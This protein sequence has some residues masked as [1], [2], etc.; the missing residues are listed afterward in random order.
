MA[1]FLLLLL[2]WAAQ[3]TRVF[4]VESAYGEA[5]GC[6]GCLAQA[7]LG[8]DAGF[9]IVWLALAWAGFVLK[10]PLAAR[11][12]RFV[13]VALLIYYV[14]DIYV[15]TQFSSRM[16]LA[17]LMVVGSTPGP[18]LDHLAATVEWW[19]WGLTLGALALLFGLAWKQPDRPPGSLVNAAVALSAIAGLVALLSS[20]PVYYVHGWAV[21]SVFDASGARTFNRAY[22]P[23]TLSK[24]SEPVAAEAECRS[25]GAAANRR[26]VV[27]LI[28]ESW[29]PYQS[30]R[31]TGLND[32]TPRLDG[33]LHEHASFDRM[34]A[35]GYSTNHGLMALLTGLP[36]M[37]TLV[38]PLAR[39]SLQPAW[40]WDQTLPRQLNRAGYD[41]AFLTSGD[42]AFTGKGDW[43]AHIGFDYLEGHD[44]PFY[45][46]M[47]RLHFRAAPDAALYDRVR[48]FLS[49]RAPDASPLALVVESVSSHNPF[50]HPESRTRD[51][52]AVFRYMDE[53]AADFIEALQADGF[54]EQGGVLVVVSDHRAMK[55]ISPGELEV[56]DDE[57]HARIPMMVL[58][59]DLP[60]MDA[61]GLWVQSDVG[62]SLVALATGSACS[63]PGWRNLFEPPGAPRCVFHSRGDDR[64]L[65]EV[66]CDAG[67]GT[68]R[69]AGDDSRFLSQR[70][71]TPER[72]G[73]ILLRL[74][75]LR[76]MADAHNDAFF[77]RR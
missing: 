30:E 6:D 62:A 77:D 44:H 58:G 22:G 17:W 28:L 3:A 63:Y 8:S 20:Q 12:L 19:R 67:R 38:P 11:A 69:L 70:G 10:Q 2:A 24:F 5:A 52:E 50:I 13:C 49:E 60:P 45:D 37:A 21:G 42:L 55:A 61:S 66:Y 27:V 72:Q 16:Y 1:L 40:G 25:F 34:M 57:A 71:L 68:V 14:L 47:K 7:A 33:L 48:A 9:W 29:S 18:V 59:E 74:A 15:M 51:E 46:G 56:L 26:D 76:L 39:R 73:E 4:I 41:T 31:L 43:L 53:T 54:M 32:W 23:A 36:V 35:S 75:R 64:N 65:V